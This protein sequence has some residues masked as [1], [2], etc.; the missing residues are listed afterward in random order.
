MV[1]YLNSVRKARSLSGMLSSG[2][3]SLPTLLPVLLEPTVPRFMVSYSWIGPL[4]TTARTLARVLPDCW[5]DTR[6]VSTPEWPGSC[7]RANVIAVQTWCRAL[8]AYVSRRTFAACVTGGYSTRN[9]VCCNALLMSR[10]PSYAKLSSVSELL[11]GNCDNGT[12]AVTCS[13][14]YCRPD[15]DWWT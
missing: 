5:L 9:D 6:Q 12:L 14:H 13:P 8:R 1:T 3:G 2:K 10:A 7:H 4:K 15:G 11:C